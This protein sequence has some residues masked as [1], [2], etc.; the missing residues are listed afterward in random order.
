MAGFDY[1]AGRSNNMVLAESN[2][3]VTIGRWA[4]RHGVSARA[5]VEV[6]RPSEAHHTGTG[7]VGKSRL[8]PVIGRAVEPSPAELSAMRAWD[9]G[10]RPRV[11]GWYV[12][13]TKDYSGPYGRKRNVPTVGLYRDDVATAPKDLIRLEESEF[14]RAKAFEGKALRAWATGFDQIA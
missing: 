13:W 14:E 1:Q 3:K 2:G 11:M 5:A 7:R 6:M 9:R 12:R 10:D 4:K 8:T